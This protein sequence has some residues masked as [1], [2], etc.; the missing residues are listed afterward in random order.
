L[1]ILLR[2]FGFHAPI[3]FIIIIFP[4][5]RFCLYCLEHLVFLLPKTFKLFDFPRYWLWT[6]LYTFCVF[7][8]KF[9]IFCN[10]VFCSLLRHTLFYVKSN[11]FVDQNKVIFIISMKSW[12]MSFLFILSTINLWNLDSLADRLIVVNV[13]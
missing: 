4:N 11:K 8:L 6:Y 9:K 12:T 2:H 13:K 1:D 5:F 7:Y 10:F 3:D